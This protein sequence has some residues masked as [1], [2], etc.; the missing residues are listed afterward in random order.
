MDWLR[1]L[2]LA[3]AAKKAGRIAAEGL[4]AVATEGGQG[5]VVEVNSE[6]DFVARNEEFQA[7]ARNIA[8]V[9]LTAGND[10]DG[11]QNAAYPDGGTVTDAVTGLVAKIGENMGLRRAETVGVG[12]GV[13]ASYIHGAVVPG[14]G[15]IGVIVGLESEGD[16]ARLAEIGHQVAMHIAAASPQCVSVGDVDPA[17]LD[18]E[19]EVLAEQARASGKPEEIVEKMVEGR[20]RKYYEEVVLLDQVFVIDGETKVGK[21]LENVATEIGK[22]ISVSGFV[23][24][25][26]GEGIERKD[27]DFAAEV[28]ATLAS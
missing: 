22:P 9:A 2:G 7:L 6:T 25:E 16:Q 12:A 18:R 4:V 23:R 5:A 14:L 20:L 3:A 28:A 10:V 21:A 24:F 8:G 13:V 26:L 15:R 11:L 27:E 19:R 17:A 1:K